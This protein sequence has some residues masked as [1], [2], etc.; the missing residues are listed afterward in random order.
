[1]GHVHLLS[2][3]LMTVKSNTVL[4]WFLR[5]ILF[6]CFPKFYATL[7]ITSQLC[8]YVFIA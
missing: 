1:M 4:P 2:C 6:T 5:P 8:P 7:I 3:Q